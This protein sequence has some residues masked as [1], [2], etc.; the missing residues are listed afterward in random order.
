MKD[1]MKIQM[2]ARN[3]ITREIAARAGLIAVIVAG[4][5]FVG[6]NVEGQSAELTSGPHYRVIDLGVPGDGFTESRGEKI[7][8]RGRIVGLSYTSN[9][10]DIQAVFW[11]NPRSAPIALSGGDGSF[12]SSAL[13]INERGWM[14]GDMG[15]MTASSMHA[16]VWANSNSLPQT[17]PGPG[18]GLGYNGISINDHGQ[19]VGNAFSD[20]D[21]NFLEPLFWA[22]RSSLPVQLSGLPGLSDTGFFPG[23]MLN[24]AGQIVGTA[25]NEDDT[26]QHGVFWADST[27]PATELS[28][29]GELDQSGAAGINNAG[30]IVG[31]AYNNDSGITHGG[32]W[33]TGGSSPIDLGALDDQ[34]A[35]AEALGINDQ[36]QIV[37][38][39]YNADFSIDHAVYWADKSSAAIDLNSVIPHGSDWVLQVA[40]DVNSSRIIVGYGTIGGHTHAFALIPRSAQEDSVE[41]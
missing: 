2:K 33:D 35:S 5:F 37:G 11:A 41:K 28:A 26:I 25:N 22:N 40:T 18:G 17:L 9:V 38:D 16:V 34:L 30:Q 4:A 23:R 39:A 10:S 8:S 27:S 29:I 15:K 13:G 6:Q 20:A 1:L 32:L 36:G 31:V 21:P 19:M 12:E 24:N 3:R 14:I 7:N